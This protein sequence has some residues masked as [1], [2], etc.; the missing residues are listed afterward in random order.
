MGLEE[1]LHHVDQNVCLVSHNG[2]G[3]TKDMIQWRHWKIND[4]PECVLYPTGT[5]EDRN[6]LF[7]PVQFQHACVELS[8]NCLEG[9]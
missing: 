4:G 9:L 5:L 7:F 6:H 8:A 1:L 3:N 2:Q